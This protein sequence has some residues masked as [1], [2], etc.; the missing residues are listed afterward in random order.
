M[1]SDSSFNSPITWLVEL[2][3]GEGIFF[4]ETTFAAAAA[5]VVVEGS[6]EARFDAAATTGEN[7]G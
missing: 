4:V 1:P 5:A 3:L 6:A 2:T 7:W